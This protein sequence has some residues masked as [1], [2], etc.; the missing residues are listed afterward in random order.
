MYFFTTLSFLILIAAIW[1]SLYVW[2]L[3]VALIFSS[4]PP[5]PQCF[6]VIHYH[7][8]PG[9]LFFPVFFSTVFALHITRAFKCR[10]RMGECMCVSKR[11]WVR[12]CEHVRAYTFCLLC[13][14][15]V[16]LRVWERKRERERFCH[17]WGTSMSKCTYYVREGEWVFVWLRDPSNRDKNMLRM[18]NK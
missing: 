3:C 11:E 4:P 2:T 16:L 5:H 1:I 17:G 14:H 10:V 7:I 15:Q 9:Y 8:Y 13:A 12:V 6:T 18:S